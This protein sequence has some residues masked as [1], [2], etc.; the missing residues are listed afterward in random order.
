MARQNKQNKLG[1]QKHEWKDTDADGEKVNYR[2]IHHGNDWRLIW[3]YKVGRNEEISWNDVEEVTLE[4]WESLR[5]I[6][7][8]KYQRGRVP[9]EIVEALDAKIQ[10]LQTEEN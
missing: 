1:N 10:D 4:M 5:D 3:S 2:A 9:Y 7:W 8:R 6:L